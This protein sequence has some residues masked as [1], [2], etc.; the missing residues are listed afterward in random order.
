MNASQILQALGMQFSSYHI[1]M[2]R[3]YEDDERMLT[4][5]VILCFSSLAVSNTR[6]LVLIFWLE[7]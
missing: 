2:M 3:R 6:S 7:A 5:V 4:A 1:G